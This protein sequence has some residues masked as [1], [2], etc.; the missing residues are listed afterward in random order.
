MFQDQGKF[1][2]RRIQKILEKMSK[3]YWSK[4]PESITIV[5]DSSTKVLWFEGFYIIGTQTENSWG[6]IVENF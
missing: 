1:C 4:M 6:I 2:G 5:F 3:L